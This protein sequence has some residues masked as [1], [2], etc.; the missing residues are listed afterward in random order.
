VGFVFAF[1]FVVS[2]LIGL[3]LKAGLRGGIRVSE[4]AEQVGLDLTQHSETGYA[5]ERI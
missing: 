1:S 3:G 4:E 2:G 5:L